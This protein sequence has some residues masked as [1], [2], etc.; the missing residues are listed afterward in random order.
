MAARKLPEK[1]EE[2]KANYEGYDKVAKDSGKVYQKVSAGA[3]RSATS[4]AK[5]ELSS[6]LGIDNAP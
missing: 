4:E 5:K 2:T 1:I 6:T 3:E